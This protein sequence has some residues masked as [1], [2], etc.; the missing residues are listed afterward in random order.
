[1]KQSG[2]LTEHIARELCASDWLLAGNITLAEVMR[3]L[4]IS[5]QAYW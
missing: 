3:H 2:Q 4:D 1:M 5:S